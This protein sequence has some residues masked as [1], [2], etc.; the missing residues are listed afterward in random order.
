M[1]VIQT[2][3]AV[4]P[5]T[6]AASSAVGPWG[7]EVPHSTARFVVFTI[8]VPGLR[9]LEWDRFSRR[10]WPAVDQPEW[11]WVGPVC[12]GRNMATPPGLGQVGHGYVRAVA[13]ATDAIATPWHGRLITEEVSCCVPAVCLA[14]ACLGQIGCRGTQPHRVPGVPQCC[15]S[16]L[17]D[18]R[19]VSR[20]DRPD[21]SRR[22]RPWR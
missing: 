22:W 10:K 14:S 7:V 11:V 12:I 17:L 13:D 19:F 21:L 2:K 3:C 18:G 8:P 20:S 16:D 4:L 6:S 1:S 5:G 9:V 15:V